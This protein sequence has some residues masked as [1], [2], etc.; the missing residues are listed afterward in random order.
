MRGADDCRFRRKIF[1]RNVWSPAEVARVI[2]TRSIKS[3]ARARP[4]KYPDPVLAN[5]NWPS[6][7][8]THA[9]GVAEKQ[10]LPDRREGKTGENTLRHT[11]I[12][13]LAHSSP[14]VWE[15]VK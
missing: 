4:P 13:G 1:D 11:T 12:P 10:S 14:V 5:G 7:R 15:R 8:G 6:F 3:T 2:A 9:S